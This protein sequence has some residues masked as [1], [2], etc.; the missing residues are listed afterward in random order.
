LSLKTH[1]RRIYFCYLRLVYASGKVFFAENKLL[2]LTPGL[3]AKAVILAGS[4]TI[5]IYTGAWE[6]CTIGPS[7][8]LP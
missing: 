8:P 1:N 5:G 2:G 7:T 3:I 4:L 6:A